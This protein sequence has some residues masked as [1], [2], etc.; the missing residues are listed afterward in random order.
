MFDSII[1]EAD[2]KFNLGGKAGTLLSALLALMTDGNHGGFTGFLEKFN[3]AGLG[4]TVSSWVSSDAN[5]TIS[6]EQLESALGEATLNN[7]AAQTGTDYTTATSA[8]AFMTPH[9]IDALTPNG[10]VPQ[11]G[12]LLTRIGSYL[13]GSTVGSAFGGI[14]TTNVGETFD[15]IGTAAVDDNVR[16][17]GDRTGSALDTVDVDGD[18]SILKWLIP[19]LLLGLLIVL[20]YTFCGK[21]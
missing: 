1:N 8:T 21:N 17:F 3:V 18:D 6:N 11:D 20:G 10:V 4:N 9:V 5:T 2:A 7:I 12:D 19:L 16:A 14:N 13:T 15:R